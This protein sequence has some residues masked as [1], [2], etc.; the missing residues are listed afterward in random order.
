MVEGSLLKGMEA[1]HCA[2]P[3]SDKQFLRSMSKPNKPKCTTAA[4]TDGWGPERLSLGN[5][6]LQ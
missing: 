3:D 5:S 1:E 6:Q 4:A 2:R